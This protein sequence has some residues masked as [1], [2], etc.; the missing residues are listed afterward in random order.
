MGGDVQDLRRP[1]AERPRS[2]HGQPAGVFYLK[3]DMYRNNFPLLALATY[4]NARGGIFRPTQH[5]ALKA[6][7]QLGVFPRLVSLAPQL[8]EVFNGVFNPAGGTRT[9]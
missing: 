7:P 6:D 1:D 8:R 5:A 3:Y 4:A 9:P 2:E